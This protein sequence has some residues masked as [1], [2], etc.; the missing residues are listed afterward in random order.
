MVTLDMNEGRAVQGQRGVLILGN[1]VSTVNAMEAKAKGSYD[2]LNG[3]TKLCS[4]HGIKY[5]PQNE[6]INGFGI[7]LNTYE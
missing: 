2:Y 3:L 4:K 5:L 6:I 1:M 7:S